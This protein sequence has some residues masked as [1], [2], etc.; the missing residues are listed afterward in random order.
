MCNFSRRAV[1]FQEKAKRFGAPSDANQQRAEQ[2]RQEWEF[3]FE[4]SALGEAPNIAP[5][6]KDG[7]IEFGRHGMSHR[8][9][10][11]ASDMLSEGDQNPW[12]VPQG[13]LPSDPLQRSARSLH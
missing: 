10:K 1:A 4:Q 3:L 5:L 6:F 12:I 11:Y 8:A 2:E 7:A 13:C 9:W